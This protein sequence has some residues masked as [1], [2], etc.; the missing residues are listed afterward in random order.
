[1]E[2]QI[3]FV[4]YHVVKLRVSREQEELVGQVKALAIDFALKKTTTMSYLTS[5]PQ[6]FRE[7]NAVVLF[8]SLK[9]LE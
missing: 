9:P 6:K 3:S 4:S 1:M 5:Y 2:V 7:L 8:Y